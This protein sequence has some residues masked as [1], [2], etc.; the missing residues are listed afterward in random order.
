MPPLNRYTV[1]GA[2]IVVLLIVNIYQFIFADWGLV[3]VRVHDVPLAQVIK[4]IERQG[5]VT[6]YT[7]IDPTSTLSM[8]VIR[9]SVAEAMESLAANA[10]GDGF[11]G[12]QWRLAFF[13]APNS[14]AVKEEIRG[15]ESGSAGDDAKVFSYPT[16]LQMLSTEEPLPAADPRLQTWPG[17]KPPAPS[18]S[19]APASTNAPD[20]DAAPPD[21]PPA[22]PSTVQDYLDALAQAADIY[23]M[24]PTSW[25]PKISGPPSTGSSITSAVHSVVGKA[26]GSVEQAFILVAHARGQRGGGGPNRGFAGGDNNWAATDDRTQNAINGLPAEARPV[27]LAQLAQERD[28]HKQLAS[29]PR[30]QRRDLWRKHMMDHMG[31]FNNWRQS[32][33]KRA[34]MYQHLVGN[35]QAAR[36]S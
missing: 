14:A 28:F 2:I 27:A 24:V 15:F 16:P 4:S 17:L 18:P 35:R 23:V 21:A 33:E 12:A 7:N 25:E 9:V 30:D 34:Q 1:G 26:R 5:H 22:P 29:T 3:T 11:R 13:A 20:G 8:D 32:P 10:G 19:P 31:A 36:G 6:I